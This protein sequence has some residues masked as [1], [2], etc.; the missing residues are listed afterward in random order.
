MA[1]HVVTTVA[2]F[3]AAMSGGAY[4][5]LAADLYFEGDSPNK[6][7][8]FSGVFDGRGHVLDGI[9]LK[10]DQYVFCY[11][12]NGTIR[13]VAITDLRLGVAAAL[14]GEGK[15][16][17]ENVY[18]RASSVQTGY[19]GWHTGFFGSNNVLEGNRVKNCLGRGGPRGNRF[20]RKRV[21]KQRTLRRA[22]IS[23][24]VL[25]DRRHRQMY[26]DERDE[27][28]RKSV[29]P[30]RFCAFRRFGRLCG[31]CRPRGDDSGGQGRTKSTSTIGT[32]ISGRLTRTVSPCQRICRNKK[33]L[34]E[35]PTESRALVTGADVF[36]KRLI[37][38]TDMGADCDDAVALALLLQ[39]MR[40]G[41]A[42]FCA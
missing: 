18:V 26:G 38:D 5:V 16:L 11:T 15:G 8:V 7:G 31:I 1:S 37:L 19:G 20:R 9:T 6:N 13:N 35:A 10:N 23:G 34:P 14:Y 24:R 40:A 4:V 39:K 29:G 28:E 3:N 22:G 27:A 21:R 2:E 32:G 17:A 33:N 41:N 25:Y 42:K 36:M 30:C 12:M